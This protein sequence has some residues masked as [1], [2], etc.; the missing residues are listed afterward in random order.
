MKALARCEPRKNRF[1]IIE[2]KDANGK[3][4]Y[5]LWYYKP[6]FWNKDNWVPEKE[7]GFK[8]VRVK[9]FESQKDISTFIKSKMKFRNIVHEG[10][11]SDEA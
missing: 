10:V 9:K 3:A 7:Y 6:T 1:R 8:S 4:H 11:L 2:E 5:E